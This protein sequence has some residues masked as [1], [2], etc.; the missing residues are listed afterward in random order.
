M[1]SKEYFKSLQD[2]DYKSLTQELLAL[3]KEQFNLRMQAAM[4]Q[5]GQSHLAVAVKRKIAQVKMIQQQ[6]KVSA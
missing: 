3:R 5:A 6:K 2:K 4:G 1:K